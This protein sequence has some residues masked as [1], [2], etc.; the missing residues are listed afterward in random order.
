MTKLALYTKGPLVYFHHEWTHFSSRSLARYRLVL[1]PYE[2]L[3]LGAN[4]KGRQAKIGV[5]NRAVQSYDFYWGWGVG[6]VTILSII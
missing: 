3:K 4:P 6:V 1:L 2:A 5:A